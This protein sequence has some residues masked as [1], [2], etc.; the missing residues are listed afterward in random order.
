MANLD[1][2]LMI[3][4]AMVPKADAQPSVEDGLNVKKT[5]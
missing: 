2:L 5:N 3:P 4:D 1:F